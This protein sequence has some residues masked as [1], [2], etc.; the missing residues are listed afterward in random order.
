MCAT[1]GRRRLTELCQERVAAEKPK[2]TADGRQAGKPRETSFPSIYP[3]AERAGQHSGRLVYL[4]LQ[5]QASAS[6]SG[7]AVCC[8]GSV[9]W[10][11]IGVSA[12][13]IS[14]WKSSGGVCAQQRQSLSARHNSFTIKNVGA[15][16]VLS[17]SPSLSHIC[18][19][20]RPLWRIYEV[21]TFRLRFF[22]ISLTLAQLIFSCFFFV[23]FTDNFSPLSSHSIS[24]YLLSVSPPV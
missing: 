13:S 16:P 21:P 23:F 12:L 11:V 1:V 9:E 2:K 7:D 3:A 19:S 8:S 20:A 5:P 22:F 18:T 24:C 6:A 14:N 10:K 4:Y 15:S 17:L